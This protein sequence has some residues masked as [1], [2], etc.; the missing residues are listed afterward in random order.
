[1]NIEGAIALVT[2]ANGDI[3]QYYVSALQEAKATRIYACARKIESL[4]SMVEADP[5]RIVPIALDIT[6]LAS[7][8]AAAKQ[9]QDV[10][11]LINNAGIGLRKSLIS[12]EDLSSAKAEMDVN[13][14]GTLSMC[15][16]FAPV[17]KA[18]GGGAII[19]M[20]SI[21]G[22]SNFPGNA[23]YSVS[24]AAEI[25][26]TQG[27]RSEL[28]SQGTLVVGVM[29]GT[30]DTAGSKDFPDPKVSPQ[31]VVEDALNGVREG[32]EDIYPGDQAK[33]MEK[34]LREDPKSLEKTMAAMVAS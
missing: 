23:S 15:R 12:A 3:G 2:G 19:N 4:A 25:S 10:N 33:G 20:L 32:I 22:K 11:L 6:D 9:A 14:M 28:A 18:N 7:V 26:M 16:A 1:M 8:E 17:L 21:L 13:Y 34:Q 30:V 27:V 5:E 31:V 29:P 24:K